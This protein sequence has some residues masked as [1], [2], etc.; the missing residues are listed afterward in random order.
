MATG[1]PHE[2][3]HA[4]LADRYTL[5]EELG[6]GGMATVYRAHD[7]KHDRRVA[8]KVIH[9]ELAEGIGPKRFE[10]EIRTTATLQHP[11]I[12]PLLDSGTAGDL[13]YYVAP[14]IEGKSLRDFIRAGDIPIETA[15]K[16]ACDVAEALDYAHRNGIVHRDIKP[17]NIMISDGQAVVTDFGIARAMNDSLTTALTESG[18]VVG[19]LVYIS[20]E[21]LSGQRD[22]D[23]RAD[24]Y[25]L[26]C[27][28]YEM[29]TGRPPF[30]G[31]SATLMKAHMLEAPAPLGA[32]VANVSAGIERVVMSALEKRPDS[33]PVSAAEF[34]AALTRAAT[35][36]GSFYA[37][38]LGQHT[39][40][41][42][43]GGTLAILIGGIA[44]LQRCSA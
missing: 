38:L 28:L 2:I 40:L 42:V 11:H 32:V 36:A 35:P 5:E 23:G 6:R 21:Q 14:F 10:R 30:L 20:P 3:L 19:T 1:D 12:V 44:L 34:A 4:E 25:S 43:A 33:R 9:P 13:L 31:D 17:E 41:V 24:V 7:R 15:I 18:T 22:I 37:Q 8:I 26:G 29:L 27:V 39:W 16:I